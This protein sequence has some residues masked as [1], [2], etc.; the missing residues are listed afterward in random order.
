M[1]V[2]GV[3]GDSDSD[4]DVYSN[5]FEEAES[6]DGPMAEVVDCRGIEIGS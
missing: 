5:D 3:P 1:S 4:P 2:A 6:D